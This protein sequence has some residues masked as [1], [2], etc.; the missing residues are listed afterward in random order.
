MLI[1]L[2]NREVRVRGLVQGVGFRPAVYRLALDCDLNG[3]VF[4]DTD[5]VLIRLMGVK[6]NIQ[7]FLYR[8]EREAPPLA[9]IDSIEAKLVTQDWN[10]REFSIT[11]SHHTQGNTGISADAAS[12]QACLDEIANPNER[13]YAYPFTNCTH[14]GPRLSII[15]GIPY[16]R[17]QTTMA[18]F[19]LCDACKKEYNNPLDRRF[20]A[21]PIACHECGPE[22]FL[23]AGDVPYD[24]PATLTN[25]K[26]QQ[27][28]KILLEALKQG[29]IIAIKGIGGFHLCC[30]ATNHSAVAQLRK[31]K[32]RY[33]KPFAL[34]CDSQE[35]VARYCY[36]SIEEREALESSAAPI[37]LL[38]V[39]SLLELSPDIAPGSKLLGFMC[40]YTPLHKLICTQFPKPLIMTSGNLS[41]EPQIIDN[42]EALKK[43]SGIADLILYHNRDIAS[44]IDDSVVRSINGKIR[45]LRRARGYA[46]QAIKLPEG[47]A[48]ADKLLA[49]GGELKSTF[50]LIKK[51]YAILSQHQGDL[52]DLTTADDY[53]HSMSLYKKL[54]EF[55]PT[56]LVFDKHPEYLSSKFAQHDAE[57]Q[58]LQS[59]RVQHHHAHI[60]SAMAENQLPLDHPQVLGIALDGLGFG[61]DGNLWGGEFLLANYAGYQRLA[62]LKPIAMPG[63]AQAVKQPWRNTFAQILNSMSW[64]SCTTDFANTEI[65]QFLSTKP[66]ASLQSMIAQGYNSPTSSSAGR[67]FDAVAGALGLCTEQVHYEGQAAIELEMLADINNVLNQRDLSPYAFSLIPITKTT[68]SDNEPLWELDANPLWPALLQDLQQGVSKSI[69]SSRFHAGFINGVMQMVDQLRHQFYFNEIVLSGGCLQNAILVQGLEQAI[70]Q[71]HLTCITQALVPANDGGIALGQA[72]IAAAQLIKNP[73]Q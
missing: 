48:Q 24:I 38:G 56:H 27:L 64:E 59:I 72:A 57:Q 29:K 66:L 71:R 34:M 37:V 25:E 69:I 5:G 70:E 3:E 19:S 45:L 8:L 2:E 23:S 40:S 39:K 50:C 7:Q 30:D 55:E 63:G 65:I 60:A 41:G 67:L 28:I 1:D 54:F 13:R 21:Q 62:R 11:L 32:K 73:H 42:D 51:G 61:D 15:K 16:D 53:E 17:D 49:Y 44:R 14:C 68:G 58:Q 4:N 18:E 10:Y 9:K 47:F 31:R 46:P 22:L 26:N 33:A 52:E 43:L 12:C 20:H 6:N 35:T 36:L